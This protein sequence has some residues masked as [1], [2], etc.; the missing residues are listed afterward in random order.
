MSLAGFLYFLYLGFME[1][2]VAILATTGV[3]LL[4]FARG[5]GQ[6]MSM[7]Y[8]SFFFGGAAVAHLQWMIFSEREASKVGW[9]ILGAI[10]L[11]S[12]ISII[13]VYCGWR[14]L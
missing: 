6:R 4:M 2:W 14:Y 13:G 8:A 10:A 1:N 11:V 9:Y 5:V 12:V 3:L 7:A